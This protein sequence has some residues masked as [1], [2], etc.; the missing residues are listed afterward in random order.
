MI[1]ISIYRGSWILYPQRSQ[2]LKG[3]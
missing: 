3:S 1:E 2:A